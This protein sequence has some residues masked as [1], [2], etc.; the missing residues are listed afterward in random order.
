MRDE[1]MRSRLARCGPER[2]ATRFTLPRFV[3]E[4]KERY[5]E[6]AN[7]AAMPEGSDVGRR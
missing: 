5:R 1:S 2:V 3:E 4:M 6:A 7:R